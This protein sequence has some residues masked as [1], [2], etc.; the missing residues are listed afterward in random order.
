MKKRVVLILAITAIAILLVLVALPFLI[1]VNRFRPELESKASLALNRQVKLGHLSLSIFAGQVAAD[2]IEVADDPAFS[3][4]N[5]ITAASLKIGVE[6]KPLIFSRQLNITEIVLESPQIALMSGGNGTW[7]FSSLVRAS[8]NNLDLSKVPRQAVSVGKLEVNHGRVTVTRV[9]SSGEPGVYDDVNISVTNFSTASVFPFELGTSLP[10]GGSASFSGTAGPISTVDAARTPL[11]GNLKANN[12]NIAA[13]KLTDPG[14]GISGTVNLDE[15]L[16]SD[17]TKAT[18]TG[19]VTGSGLKLSPKGPPAP[20]VIAVKHNVDLDLVTQAV[21]IQRADIAIGKAV[22]HATGTLNHEQNKVLI[23]IQLNGANLSL[24]ELQTMFPTLD[25]KLPSNAHLQ[26]GEAFVS[27]RVKGSPEAPIISGNVKAVDF[28]LVGFNLGSQ[29]G[30]FMGLAGK[31]ISSP[32]TTFHSLSVHVEMTKAGVQVDDL[33]I[34]IP[35]VGG[36]T[37]SGTISPSGDVEIA[38]MSTPYAGV[39]GGLTKMAPADG[40][41]SGQVPILMHGTIDKPV[42]TTDTK[43]AA[44]VMAAQAAKGVAAKIGGIFKKKPKQTE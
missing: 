2:D 18:L 8:G 31:T 33:D 15:A 11:A 41:K 20:R 1:D 32:D 7:N 6:L 19:T 16:R 25:V 39:A 13:Y 34:D 40:K 12:V 30:T 10:G 42:Y 22:V 44:R 21:T 29:L 5:F 23:D 38:M 3:K 4:A 35:S 26:G 28:T 17:G 9:D 36:A 27:L 43:A 37:G 14:S 24:D